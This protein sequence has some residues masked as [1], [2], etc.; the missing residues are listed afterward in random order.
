[1]DKARPLNTARQALWFYAASGP[2][3]TFNPDHGPWMHFYK[4]HNKLLEEAFAQGIE[5]NIELPHADGNNH[6]ATLYIHLHIHMVLMILALRCFEMIS[7]LGFPRDHKVLHYR[8]HKV[9]P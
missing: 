2:T 8:D 6:H 9:M 5:S 4:E 7:M 3:Q 1:M